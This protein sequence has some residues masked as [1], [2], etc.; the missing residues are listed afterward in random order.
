MY[1]VHLISRLWE[2]FPVAWHHWHV[3]HLNSQHHHAWLQTIL[4][5][6][7]NGDTL[8]ELSIMIPK[9]IIIQII[10][11]VRYCIYCE[12]LPSHTQA[13]THTYNIHTQ[14]TIRLTFVVESS[15]KGYW[16]ASVYTLEVVYYTSMHVQHLCSI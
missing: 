11:I 9:D 10:I 14:Y 1:I 8:V 16:T 7:G 15:L 2:S 12:N 3:H 5:L 6:T 4:L 13:C